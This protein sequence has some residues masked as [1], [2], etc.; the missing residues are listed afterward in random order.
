MGVEGIVQQRGGTMNYQRS[1]LYVLSAILVACCGCRKANDTAPTGPSQTASYQYS[2]LDLNGAVVGTGTLSLSFN[3]TAVSGF[4]DIKGNV[5]EAGTGNANGEMTS[6]GSVQIQLNPGSISLVILK[7]KIEGAMLSGD[8]LLDTG[9]PPI[10]RRIGS[11]VAA[12]P[13]IGSH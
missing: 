8:R 11:F 6:D 2:A 1:L 9:D 7:G 4:R 3:G 12:P 13:G 5:P 10:D